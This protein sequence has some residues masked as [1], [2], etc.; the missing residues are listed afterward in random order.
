MSGRQGITGPLILI[1][2]GVLLILNNVKQL[3]DGFFVSL[4]HFW[5]VVLILLGIDVLL[6]HNE[7]RFGYITQIFFGII[8]I[9]G[10][11]A[12][13]WGGIPDSEYDLLIDPIDERGSDLR[14]AHLE[15]TNRFFVDLSYANMSG[16]YLNGA[17]LFFV[18]L[19]NT[20]LE[21]AQLNG[22]N[23]FFSD[24]TDASIR[25]ADVSGANIF[26]SDFG[27]TDLEGTNIGNANIMFTLGVGK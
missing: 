16:A 3:P 26:F 8:V 21:G 14:N 2:F 27:G 15:G 11:I 19:S 7:S 20:D 6:S 13:A 10:V 5:P 17:N 24:I 18:D 12:L 4:W 9:C 25:N 22:A 23:I 1:T